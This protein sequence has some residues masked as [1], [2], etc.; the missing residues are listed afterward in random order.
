MQHSSL[1]LAPSMA[2]QPTLAIVEVMITVGYNVCISSNYHLE[3]LFFLA[4]IT[5]IVESTK[6]RTI[7][8][9]TSTTTC[10]LI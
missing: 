5:L 2:M 10:A 4:W 9:Y 3:V 8:R 6:L 1:G 7:S